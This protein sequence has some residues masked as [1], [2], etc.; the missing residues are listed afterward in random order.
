MLLTSS[1]IDQAIALVGLAVRGRQRKPR[2]GV[3]N[4]NRRYRAGQQTEG[5]VSPSQL[6]ALASVE[7]LG[8]IT[9]GEL[10]AVE[11]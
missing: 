8:P 11:A 4:A 7:R 1:F 9:L 10:A 3:A 6:S 2:R 5:E